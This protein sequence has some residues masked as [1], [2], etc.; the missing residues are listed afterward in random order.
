MT[1]ACSAPA[2]APAAASRATPTATVTAVPGWPSAMA[3]IGH[4]GLTGYDS[5]DRGVDAKSNSWATGDNPDVDSVYARIVAQN[6]AM[7]GHA[8]NLAVD[9]SGV[10]D[11]LRQAKALA[12]M[13]P[14]PELILVQ[15]IDNDMQCDG[16]DAEHLPVYREGLVEVMDA[17]AAGVPDAT[18]MF[19]SQ[20]GSVERYDAAIVQVAPSHVAGSGPCDT[21]DPA[22]QQIVPEKEAGLQALVDEYFATIVDVCSQYEHCMTDG[23]AMQGME[24]EPADLTPDFNHLSEAGHAKMAAIVWQVLYG[25]QQ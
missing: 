18:V 10:V 13:D 12:S 22:T 21:V 6:P 4:S 9:G 16:T 8:V 1:T 25:D 14:K 23:G 15:S 2:P 5:K 7:T 17:L 20:W 19:V 24:V 3:A 11:L